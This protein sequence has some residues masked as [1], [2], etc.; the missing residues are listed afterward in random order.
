VPNCEDGALPIATYSSDSDVR[1]VSKPPPFLIGIPAWAEGRKDTARRK[2][3]G[4]G[5]HLRFN[6]V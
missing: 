2:D 3:C 6:H 1:G 5:E 4:S